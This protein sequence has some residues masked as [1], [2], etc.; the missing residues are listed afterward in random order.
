MMIVRYGRANCQARRSALP[1]SR[2]PLTASAFRGFIIEGPIRIAVEDTEHDLHSYDGPMRQSRALWVLCAGFLLAVAACGDGGEPHTANRGTIDGVVL[3]AVP[4]GPR[5]TAPNDSVQDGASSPSPDD[6]NGATLPSTPPP[7]DPRPDDPSRSAFH[8]VTVGAS[9]QTGTLRVPVDAGDPSKG[10]AT[11]A[12]ARHL[13]DDPDHRIGSMLMVADVSGGHGRDVVD[14][15]EQLLGQDLLD[16][17]D[18]VTWDLRGTGDSTPGIDCA[19]PAVPLFELEPDVATASG[20]RA[21]TAAAGA[22][23]ASCAQGSAGILPYAGTV[24]SARDADRIR[25]ALGEPTIS[26]FGAGTGSSL[27]AIWSTLFP[28][29]VRAAV[30]D[31]AADPTVGPLAQRVQQAAGFEAAFAAFLRHCS[32][33]AA[34]AFHNDGQAE[35]AYDALA[36]S[37]RSAPLPGG[38]YGPSVTSGVLAG[39]VTASVSNEAGWPTLERALADAQHGDGAGLQ[40]LFVR[41]MALDPQ[42]GNVVDT[43]VANAAA[44]GCVDAASAAPGSGDDPVVRDAAVGDTATLFSRQVEFIAAAPRLGAALFAPALFCADWS[45]A[46]SRTPT[47]TGAGVVTIVVVAASGDPVTPL[48]GTKRMAATFPDARLVVVAAAQHT[49]YGVDSCVVEAVDRYLIEPRIAPQSGLT[50]P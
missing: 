15:V 12:V 46:A 49:G 13:A 47:I 18:I 25:D 4:A 48:A 3:S 50:C 32:G 14:H 29:T 20:Q 23:A 19:E 16:R 27:G 36:A 11:L 30:F 5:I 35:D 1:R 7:P 22:F 6:S 10:T 2:T 42:S 31:G 21:M 45:V 40:T 33:D 38:R 8:W 24:D 41:A 28:A 9:L 39:A 44:V 26:F 37:I 43:A 17:F 34:C